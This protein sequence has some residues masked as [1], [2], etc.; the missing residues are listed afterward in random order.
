MDVGW[1]FV[2]S[3][4]FPVW[5]VFGHVKQLAKECKIVHHVNRHGRNKKVATLT[6][7]VGLHLKGL[8]MFKFFKFFQIL[9]IVLTM[10]KEERQQSPRGLH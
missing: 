7:L 10:Q 5:L 4:R 9:L 8:D 1:N 2:I 6:K 3:P